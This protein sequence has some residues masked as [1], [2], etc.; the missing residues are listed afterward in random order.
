MKFKV[1]DRV[2]VQVKV[3]ESTMQHRRIVMHLVEPVVP[4]L[5][6]EAQPEK[7]QAKKARK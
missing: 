2:I 1:F 5:S 4:G 6:V 7:H 3:E